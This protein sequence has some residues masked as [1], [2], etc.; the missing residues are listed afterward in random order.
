MPFKRDMALQN[1]PLSKQPF[2]YYYEIH[3]TDEKVFND[4][5]TRNV[6]VDFIFKESLF[7]S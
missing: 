7:V 2:K 3:P 1:I 6:K 4:F 5:L